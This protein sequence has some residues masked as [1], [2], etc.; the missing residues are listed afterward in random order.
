MLYNLFHAFTSKYLVHNMETVKAQRI[1]KMFTA[2][3][4]AKLGVVL[5]RG[6]PLG[7]RGRPT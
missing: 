4:D 7:G 5:E 6:G 3:F 2:H 1:Q